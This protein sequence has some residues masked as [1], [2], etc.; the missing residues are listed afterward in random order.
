MDQCTLFCNDIQNN[1]LFL[2]LAQVEL[3]IY[4]VVSIFKNIQCCMTTTTIT[5]T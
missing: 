1:V 4:P 3:F 2:F 5:I